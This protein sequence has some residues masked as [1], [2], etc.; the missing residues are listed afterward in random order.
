[1]PRLTDLEIAHA[2][3]QLEAGVPQHQVATAFGVAKKNSVS[4]KITGCRPK[5]FITY[6][7][8]LPPGVIFN[9]VLQIPKQGVFQEM[10]VNCVW[11][12]HW[13]KSLPIDCLAQITVILAHLISDFV[14][15]SLMWPNSATCNHCKCGIML[16]RNT[17]ALH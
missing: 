13:C 17:S 16:K 15:F 10:R 3:G 6:L 14:S 4:E 11:C 5:P 2:I 9:P 1:M 7:H 12:A 8:D